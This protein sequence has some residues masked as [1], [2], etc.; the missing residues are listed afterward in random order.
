MDA[1]ARALQLRAYADE[2]AA[3]VKCR[4]S[5][6]RTQVVFGVGN[7]DADLMF[8]GEAPGFHED[9]QG[10]P[11]VGQ[12]GKLLDRLLEGIGLSRAEIYVANVLKCLRYDA[13][14]QLGDGSWER[15]GRLVN[16][17]Y[18]GTVMS[19]DDAGC[20]VPRRVTGWHATPLGARRV[21]RLTYR[22]AKNAGA[23]R[24]GI[25]LTGDHP[26]LTERGY[27][28]VDELRDEDRIATGQGLS[29]VAR[30]V[31]CGTL[32]GD[33]SL[34]AASAY[35]RF[36]HSERQLEYATFKAEL[37][38]ELRPQIQQLS[39]AAVAGGAKTYGV[40]HVRSRA[41]RALGVLRRDFYGAKK[42]VPD[43]IA[44]QLNDRMLAI[45]FLDDGYTRI[46]SRPPA[47]GRDRDKRL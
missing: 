1:A 16:A 22:S 4:L 14:V 23:G 46:R 13:P 8:V 9:K 27:V 35:V 11:F 30:D 41:H 33:G 5:E 12:A 17:R 25:Q 7:P 15:I 24:V 3:C 39:V 37:L 38:E 31:V 34:N 47:L 18:E 36:A 29:S 10:F 6:T 42:R 19:V 2:T 28:R 40:V 20:L 45:W 44:D 21:Y 26:V 43:W 32:L